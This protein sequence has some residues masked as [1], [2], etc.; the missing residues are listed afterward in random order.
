MNRQQELER[1]KNLYCAVAIANR[2]TAPNK[3]T[4]YITTDERLDVLASLEACA[5]NLAR[6]RESDRAWKWV[7]LSMHSALQGAMVCHLSGGAQIGALKGNCA[8]S[9]LNWLNERKYVEDEV[10][11]K[12]FVASAPELLRRLTGSSHRF[13]NDC[14]Q[15]IEIT[16]AQSRSFKSLH[17]L[18]NEF[19]HFHPKGW[20]VE[21]ALIRE[22][23]SD[24]LEIL[25]TIAKDPWPFRHMAES[26]RTALD[27]RIR[28]I[29][30]LL[31]C[32][33]NH[34]EG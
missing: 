34:P 18:R 6:T 2:S 13:E 24:V 17:D 20:S 5:D 21:M 23:A 11:P 10:P 30:A 32:S 12:S 31:S 26:E 9:W 1:E 25:D 28:E 22:S 3:M 7:V 27:S 29:G 33:Q 15:V 19:T 16:E 8:K 4:E 14:G